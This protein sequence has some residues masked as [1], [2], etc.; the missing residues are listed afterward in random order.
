MKAIFACGR[1]GEFGLLGGIPWIQP[2]DLKQFKEYTM[3]GTLVMGRNTFE[4]LPCKLPG[5][6]HVVISSRGEFDGKQPDVVIRSIYDAP[7]DGIVIGGARVIEEALL[8]GLC[9][10]V[11]ITYMD[12]SF[13][14]DVRID[15]PIISECLSM[16]SYMATNEPW[17]VRVIW[18]HR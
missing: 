14:A 17:G 2:G 1:Q 13:E 16:M 6:R 12:G 8:S 5:R 3:G 15:L 10:E 9:E 4:S 7:S 11:S 18:K